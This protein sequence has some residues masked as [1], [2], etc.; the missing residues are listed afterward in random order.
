MAR[1]SLFIAFAVE[2]KMELVLGTELAHD[3]FNILHATSAFAH[4]LG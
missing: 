3:V 4:R 2:S 1:K